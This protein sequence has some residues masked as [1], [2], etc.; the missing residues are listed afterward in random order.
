VEDLLWSRAQLQLVA[1]RRQPLLG[2]RPALL[3][4]VSRLLLFL[5]LLLLVMML[6]M[7]IPSDCLSC[8]SVCL[9]V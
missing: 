9:S 2:T 6:M 3:V 8:L 1:Q 7:M 5:L 4:V